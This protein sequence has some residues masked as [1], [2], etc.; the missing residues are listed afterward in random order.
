[1]KKLNYVIVFVSDMQRSIRFYRDALGLPLKFDSPEWTEF[2][3]EGVT[4]AL[5][6]AEGGQPGAA[7]KRASAGSCQPGVGVENLDEFHQAMLS[8]QVRCIQAP[9][10]Q[11]FGVRLAIYRDPD[12]LPISVAE[13]GKK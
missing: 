13:M 9:K 1:M 5:H 7:P 8:Q 11:D 10:L 6:Q 12:G 4:L 3:T 2:A